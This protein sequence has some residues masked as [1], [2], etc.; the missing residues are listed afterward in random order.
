MNHDDP[1]VV[2]T[3]ILEQLT[4]DFVL[5]VESPGWDP[6]CYI[7]ENAHNRVAIGLDPIDGDGIS[8]ATYY[9]TEDGQSD[10]VNWAGWAFGDAKTAGTETDEIVSFLSRRRT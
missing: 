5:R 3:H 4:D 9:V 10:D 6:A 8:W 2:A 7:I 1:K